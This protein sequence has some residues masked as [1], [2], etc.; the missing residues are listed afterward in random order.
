MYIF[1]QTIDYKGAISGIASNVQAKATSGD[2]VAIMNFES[3]S[4]QFS[5]RII[6]DLTS[7]L[8]KNN[9]RIVERGNID[10]ILGEQNFQLSGYVD[11][12]S[13][14]G[15]GHMLG[16]TCI[17]IGSGENMTDYYSLNFKMMSV[18]TGEIL[19]LSTINVKYDSTIIRLLNNS[20]YN[21]ADLGNTHFLIGA[22][23]GVGFEI[24]TADEDMIG[25]GFTPKEKSN[26]AFSAS[27]YGA[28]KFTHMWSIQ[29]E[30]NFMT[31][32][33]MEISGLGYMYKID[34]QTIDIPLL[35]RFNFL[36]KTPFLAGIVIGPYIS[37]P[38]G[39]LNFQYNG[40]NPN[41][42]I[43]GIAYGIAGGFSLAFKLGPGHLVGDIRYIN[44][45][46]SL[47]IYENEYG[48]TFQDQNILIRRSINLT[49][50]YELSL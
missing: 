13:I 30:A 4:E 3:S 27:L 37:I 44:D 1:S 15:I 9:V 8:V 45:F 25:T 12:D 5:M 23:L 41:L 36:Q 28:F 40:A 50:G 7:E 33:G 2:I 32:N 47:K 20:T 18:K 34:Y 14:A 19:L 29:P 16:A 49:F 38:I 11:D 42:D 31:N 39:R 46:N 22:R 6:N 24:N 17:L 21:S 10:A 43:K 35:V 26:T 48:S